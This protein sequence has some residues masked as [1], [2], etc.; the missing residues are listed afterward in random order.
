MSVAKVI[1]IISG[2]KVSFDDA[3]KQGLAKASETVKGISGAWVKDQRVVCDN[4]KIA[5]YRVVMKVTFLL[6]S[7]APKAA[8][9]K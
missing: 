7:A 9:K 8:K 6:A 3:V 4:G 2:S 5:E 1:E